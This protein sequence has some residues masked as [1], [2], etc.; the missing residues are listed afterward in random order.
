MHYTQYKTILSSKN[1]M[2]L[3]RGCSHGCIYCDSR[4]VC[5]QMNH[6]FEYIKV[7]Q[8]AVSILETQLLK[9]RQPCM[10][11]TGAMCDPYISLDGADIGQLRGGATA[12]SPRWS[13]W[14]PSR[15]I[16]GEASPKPFPQK[17]SVMHLRMAHRL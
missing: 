5:Y 10:I 12:A 9:K 8:N 16:G 2:N 1:N 6:D 11:V 4:S 13:L 7:K 15:T 17:Q 3:Y 14:R